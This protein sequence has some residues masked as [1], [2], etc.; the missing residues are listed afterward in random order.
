MGFVGAG[1]AVGEVSELR[2]LPKE[3]DLWCDV[4]DVILSLTQEYSSK[5]QK[6]DSSRIATQ[7]HD[8]YII[9]FSL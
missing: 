8:F 9:R 4:D 6:S 3:A 7:K 5:I 2:I 1:W